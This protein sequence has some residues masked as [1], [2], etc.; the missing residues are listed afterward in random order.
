MKVRRRA[1]SRCRVTPRA[2]GPRA[3]GARERAALRTR[4]T[5]DPRRSG[6]PY[7][8]WVDQVHSLDV[9]DGSSSTST[10]ARGRW[11]SP[12]VDLD[13]S[14]VTIPRG[15]IRQI[16]RRGAS[17]RWTSVGVCYATKWDWG[18]RSRCWRACSR[19]DVLWV[20]SRPS[21]TRGQSRNDAGQP[22]RRRGRVRRGASPPR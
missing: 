4:R 20:K 15:W 8:P 13:T 2:S 1:S 14:H 19:T 12:R 18:K 21:G 3:R 17:V 5:G 6:F 7:V 16:Y 10:R 11:C 22:R 9:L